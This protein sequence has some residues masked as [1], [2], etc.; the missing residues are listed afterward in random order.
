ML[1]SPEAKRPLGRKSVFVFEPCRQSIPQQCNEAAQMFNAVHV[2]KPMTLPG[3]VILAIKQLTTDPYGVIPFLRPRGL[4]SN[5]LWSLLIRGAN[6]KAE[7]TSVYQAK[8][9]NKLNT[10]LMQS[11]ASPCFTARISPG[12]ST[13]RMGV[14]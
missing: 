8:S 11:N 5:G 4:Q 6:T 13:K 12:E 3:E 7:S 9:T 2:K 14:R 1:G 10:G